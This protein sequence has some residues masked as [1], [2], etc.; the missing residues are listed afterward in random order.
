MAE[1][2]LYGSIWRRWDLHLHTPNTKKEDRYTGNTDEEKWEGFYRSLHNYVG[3]GADPSRAISVVG[4]TDYL[5][6]DNYFKVKNEGKLP[7]CIKLIIPNIEARMTPVAHNSPINIHFLFDPSFDSQIESQFL[8]NLYFKKQTDV[9][10]AT[11]DDIVRLGRGYKADPSLTEKEAYKEG[12]SQFV[13]EPESVREVFKSKPFLRD[14]VIIVVCNKSGDGVSGARCHCEYLTESGGSQLQETTDSIYQLA[15]AIFSS[16]PKD[17]EYFLGNGVDSKDEVLRRYKTIM[18][19]VHGCDAH[20]NSKAFAPDDERFCWIKADPTFEGFKQILYEP[21]DRVF[22]G[23]TNPAWKHDYNIID[24]VE[25]ANN[26]N[27]SSSPIYFNENLTCIIGGKST[28]KSLLLHNMALALDREQTEKKS[29]KSGTKVQELSDIRVIWRDNYTSP[30][31]QGDD[32]KKSRKIVYIPQTYLNRLSDE[33]EETTEID[34]IIEDIVLQNEDSAD[35]YNSMRVSLGEKTAEITNLIIQLTS[36][37]RDILKL[38]NER[39]EKGDESGVNAEI[40]KLE[41]QLSEISKQFQVSENDIL[42]YQK[43]KEIVERHK[44]IIKALENAKNH[45][46]STGSVIFNLAISADDF[47][48]FKEEISNAISFTVQESDKIW[49]QQKDSIILSIEERIVEFTNDMNT[50]LAR[51]AELEP[52]IAGHG[53]ISQ[54]S[55]SITSEKQRLDIIKDLSARIEVLRTNFESNLDKVCSTFFDF[56]NIQDSYAQKINN[57]LKELPSDD[58]EFRVDVV[59]RGEQFKNALADALNNRT[60]TYFSLK[61]TLSAPSEQ[62]V[63]IIFLKELINSII[64]SSQ[65]SLALKGGRDIESGLRD[66]FINWYNINYI[67]K[68]DGDDIYDM[69]PGKKALVLLRLLINLAES[70]CPILIDQ[71]EDDLDNRSIF[72]EL[73]EFIK[74]RKADRQIIIVTHNANI[75]VGS[76]AELVI[77]ANQHGKNSPNSKYRFEYR[78]GAIENN[79]P[80]Q[81]EKNEF[82]QGILN[83]QGIQGHICDVLE[84]GLA[85]FELRGKKYKS[86]SI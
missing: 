11:R 56:K 33:K 4:V 57:R 68:L 8:A 27:F 10:R 41:S 17:R 32:A 63:T 5:S 79:F 60:F 20:E 39:L 19:C 73:I 13:L 81:L 28:G 62:N 55:A 15:D 54:I 25:I 49:K 14:K 37:H 38:H 72:G 2:Y 58:L 42:E 83:A 52:K 64:S 30:A 65:E 36:Q 18:P 51:V 50:K 1:N 78:A 9:F 80:I 40:L 67:V 85:A 43:S 86:L 74:K 21:Q 48:V 12:I 76:D 59:F 29:R 69:S 6:L 77:V 35:N 75:V 26:E 47:S 53:H 22:V 46:I 3:N 66:I 45:L 16:N 82:P 7:P 61:E 44:R 84:G 34:S 24:R 31:Q 23:N 71:P 70:K